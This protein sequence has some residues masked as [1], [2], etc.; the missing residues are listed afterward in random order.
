MGED[1]G[2]EKL[3]DKKEKDIFL[4]EHLLSDF[5]IFKDT[6]KNVVIWISSLIVYCAVFYDGKAKL[7]LKGKPE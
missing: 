6:G 1:V 3:R 7:F 4:L 5:Q 2:E